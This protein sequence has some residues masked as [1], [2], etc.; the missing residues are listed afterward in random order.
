MIIYV[1]LQLKHFSFNT[2]NFNYITSIPL[3]YVY[4][5]EKLHNI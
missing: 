4:V 2:V 5:K 1:S 3:T